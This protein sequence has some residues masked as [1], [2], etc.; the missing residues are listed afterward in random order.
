MTHIETCPG[1]LCSYGNV[2]QSSLGGAAKVHGNGHIVCH[3]YIYISTAFANDTS[4]NERMRATGGGRLILIHTKQERPALSGRRGRRKAH[5]LA[6]PA[7]MTTNSALM[8]RWQTQ[9]VQNKNHQVTCS[10]YRSLSQMWH[11]LFAEDRIPC[12]P[13]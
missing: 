5:P 10:A 13:P 11:N 9:L 4:S 2:T 8:R 7:Q 12:P 1:K 3:I 6:L